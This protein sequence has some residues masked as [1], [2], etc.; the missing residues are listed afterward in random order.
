MK[1][2]IIAGIVLIIVG[3]LVTKYFVDDKTELRYVV[4]DRIPTNFFDG[5]DTESI[6]Q[7]ELLNT[8]DIELQRI[9]IKINANV[10]D[11]YIQKVTSSDSIITSKN[12]RLL[13][14]V[15]PQIPPEGNIKIIFK[16]FQT[17]YSEMQKRHV[18]RLFL[19]LF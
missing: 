5:N 3:V 14:F 4:S 8:G 1:N 12:N 2:S 18:L 9:I 7:L 10:I 16:S 19:R 11:Y 13:E 15:Y 17:S 6:Q